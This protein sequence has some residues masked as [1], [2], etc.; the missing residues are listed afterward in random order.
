M[1]IKVI[2]PNA[3]MDKQTLRQREEML[4]MY[5][6]QSTE[7]SVDCIDEGPVSIETSYD[8]LLAGKPLLDKIVQAE[9]EKFN[10]IVVYCGSDPCIEAAREMVDI[11]VIGAGKVSFLLANDLAHRFSILT[12]LGETIARD[13]EHYRSLGLD[14]TRLASI[15]SVDI[16]VVNMREDLYRTLDVLE[17]IGEKCIEE[18]GAHALVLSCMGMA[19]LG[20][21]LQKKLGVPVIDPA[22]LSIKYAELLIG[23]GLNY[24]RKSYVKYFK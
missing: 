19:G 10:A 3:G 11:P 6:M 8:E 16:P 20:I 17:R 1:R 4:S 2:I 18:D 14:I 9:K 7:I 12:V 23:L 13:T 15:K 21:P 22:H 24:S 5:A